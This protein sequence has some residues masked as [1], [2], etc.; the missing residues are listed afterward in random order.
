[1]S[2]LS[3]LASPAQ[4]GTYLRTSVGA[5][6]HIRTATKRVSG[7]RTNK[8]D[9]AGRR[10]GPKVYENHF[11]KPGQII[12]RQRGSKIHPGEN[13]R[14]GKDH[15]IYA[16]EPGYVKFYLDPFHPLRKYVGLS[17][18]RELTLPSPHFEPRVRRFGYELLTGEAAEIEEARMS[19]KEELAT[20]MLKENAEREAA[21]AA[22]QLEDYKSTVA[23]LSEG[24]SA[25]ST[26]LGA[27][28]LAFIA[29]KLALDEPYQVAAEQ[30][31]F[32]HIYALELAAKRGELDAES[33]A[34]QRKEHISFA[35]D[36]DNK[37]SVDFAGKI[38]A[39]MTPEARE[40]KQAEVLG[41]LAEYKNKKISAKDKEAVSALI[42]TPG[43]F[44]KDTR[45]EL[46]EEYLPRVLPE[47]V[48]GTVVEVDGNKK[49]PKNAIAV[50]TFNPADRSVKTVFR[51]K[52]AFLA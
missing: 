49:P 52:D 31:T 1:M 5:I 2:F 24:L 13:V 41:A 22:A 19:R 6:T 20:P 42:A 21:E 40:G 48:P 32:N 25:E 10:L 39:T 37:L 34:A 23:S 3:L 43:V 14:I 4:V 12:M 18:K 46:T 47:T 11:V 51:T 35:D 45:R 50:R 8:N 44:S 36:F 33:L 26:T 17:L 29:A 7:S 9:S 16:V 27:A 28:R 38:F 30:A 15:T